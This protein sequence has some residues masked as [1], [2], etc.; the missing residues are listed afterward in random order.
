MMRAVLRKELATLWTSPVPW[1]AGAALQAVLAVL[2]VDQLQGRAQ[3]VVQPLFPIA[4]LLLVVVVP[5]LAM[6]AFA[7]EKRSGNL[8]VLLAAPV[9]MVPVAIGKWLAVWITAVAVLLP[10]LALAGLTALWGDPDPG[11]IIAG[12]L[13][14]ALLAGAVGAIGVAASAATSSQALAALLTILV[15]LVLWFVGSATSGSSTSRLLG[16]LSLSERLRTFAAG[17]IDV[18]D[19][20]FFVGV[21]VVGV[22]AAAVLVRP[23]TVPAAVAVAALV[24]TV[25]ASGQHS[26]TDLTEHETLTL[27]PITRDVVRAA[28]EHV[29]ITAFVGRGS[30]G[31]VEAVSLLDRYARLSRRIDVEV[32]DPSDEPGEA[33]RLGIDP[34]LGGV[35]VQLG[36]EVELGAGAT[37]QD[38]TSTLARLIRG[39]DALIC[40]TV[41]NGE[42][43]IALPTYD[44]RGIDLLVEEVIPDHCTVVVVAGPQGDLGDGEDA[45]AEWVADDGKLLALL[46][47]AADVTLDRVLAPFGLGVKRGVVFEGDPD[48]IVN[49]DESAPIIRRYSSAHPVVR[50]LP[51][52]YFPGV[53][54]VTVD[55]DL[56]APGLTVS[57]LADTSEISYLETEPLNPSFDPGTDTGGPVTIAAAADQSRVVSDEEVAR[58]RIVVVGDV[59][60]A[61]PDVA[62]AAANAR[63]LAQAIGWLALDDELIPLSSNLPEDRPLELTDSRVAYARFLGVGAIPGLL[64]LG[65][66][67]VWAVRRRR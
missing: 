13:G 65:G 11:P 53:Q 37:E 14:L 56:R 10:A 59:D 52:T 39:N 58:T 19:V 17:G 1:V 43:E 18:G 12:F 54:E 44:V 67:I 33:R 29:K 25:L 22:L 48:S 57:R 35:A 26:L 32:V 5:V 66:A 63:F 62:G 24:L 47:P 3:A 41:S 40:V 6:R 9:P 16:G 31:R 28:D 45:L 8:D 34:Q 46:D 50:N 60:F 21:I 20:A 49:G 36:D 27:T 55:D 4:G 23:A 2:F 42:A 38:I 51:P 61:T 15:G 30:P 7:E 64:L